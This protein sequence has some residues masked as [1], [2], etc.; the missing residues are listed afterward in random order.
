MFIVAQ[1]VIARSKKQPKCLSTKEWIKKLW[2][3]YTMQ[4]YSAIK[5]VHI[6]LFINKWMQLQPILTSEIYQTHMYKYHIVS[7]V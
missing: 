7:L 3:F 5:N 4:Y 2:F 1:F 6:E